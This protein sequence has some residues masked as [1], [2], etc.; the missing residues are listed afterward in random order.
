LSGSDCALLHGFTRRPC[1]SEAQANVATFFS[2]GRDHPIA[3]NSPGAG[4]GRADFQV[5][6]RAKAADEHT[7]S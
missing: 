6:Q 1:K 4:T 3:V 7:K 2:R 5:T